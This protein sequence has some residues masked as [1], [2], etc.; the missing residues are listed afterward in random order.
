MRVVATGVDCVG[1]PEEVDCRWEQRRKQE[2][3]VLTG[4]Y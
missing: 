2:P 3:G 4:V 1:A